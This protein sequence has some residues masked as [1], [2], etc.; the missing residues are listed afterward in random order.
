MVRAFADDTAVVL[1]SAPRDAPLLSVIF[2]E[3]S[4]ISGL[5]LNL[6]KC[7]FIPLWA[8]SEARAAADLARWEPAWAAVTVRY[9]GTYLGFAVGPEKGS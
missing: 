1:E 9:W 7:V 6:P 2:E 4:M 3:F 8:D 5:S